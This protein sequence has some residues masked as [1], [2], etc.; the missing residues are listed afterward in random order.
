MA[1]DSLC[2][3]QRGPRLSATGQRASNSKRCQ[4]FGL[5]VLVDQAGEVGALRMSWNDEHRYEG[6]TKQGGD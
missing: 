4:P 1:D 2:C 3:H 5:P 6:N